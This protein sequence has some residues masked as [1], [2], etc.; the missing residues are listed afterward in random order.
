MYEVN[1]RIYLHEWT[2]QVGNKYQATPNP[3]LFNSPRAY[4]NIHGHH[5]NCSRGR[6]YKAWQRNKDNIH[7]MYCTKSVE[8]AR[9]RKFLNIAFA[10]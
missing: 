8:H 10:E 4:S 9:R 5:L 1:Q 6:L 2:D 7:A 3:V